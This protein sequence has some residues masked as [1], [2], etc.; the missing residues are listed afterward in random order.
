LLGSHHPQLP[1]ES[2]ERAA[3]Q[4]EQLPLAKRFQNKA[5]A[6]LPN[7]CTGRVSSL[8]P[9]CASAS[10]PDDAAFARQAGMMMAALAQQALSRLSWVRIEI[11][12][13]IGAFLM[14]A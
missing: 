6:N 10:L 3:A 2:L 8:V 1:P 4:G 5:H 9:A 14:A 13:L 12:L 11:A 7:L